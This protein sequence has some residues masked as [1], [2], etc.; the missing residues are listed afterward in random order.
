MSTKLVPQIPPVW[1]F[2]AYAAL[3]QQLQKGWFLLN[4]EFELITYCSA[5][6]P[7]P[8]KKCPI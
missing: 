4:P 6:L 5:T 3:F 7:S 2:P 1:V 8:P